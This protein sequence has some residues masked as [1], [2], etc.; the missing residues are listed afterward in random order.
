MAWYKVAEAGALSEPF[1]KKVKVAGKD[2]CLVGYEGDVYALS[3]R[4]P[5]A[6][7]DLSGGWCKE[8]KIV[9]PVHRYAYNLD[10]GRGAEGQG[11]YVRTY[12]I[13]INENGIFIS[14]SSLS[15]RLKR[16]FGKGDQF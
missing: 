6:G 12:P 7:E 8:G 10:N 14:I 15:E 11:D 2:I 9:C 3:A 4:C 5:H 13:K 16:L 1:I